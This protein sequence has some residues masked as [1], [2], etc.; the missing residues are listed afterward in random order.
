MDGVESGNVFVVVMVD[1]E[2]NNVFF[3]DGEV[4]GDVV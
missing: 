4:D 1:F 3:D 2:V